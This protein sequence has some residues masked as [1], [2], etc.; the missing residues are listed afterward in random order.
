MASSKW[1]LCGSEVPKEALRRVRVC[2]SA[3]KAQRPLLVAR[4][5][6]EQSLRWGTILKWELAGPMI[7]RVLGSSRS[8]FL[9]I[10][11]RVTYLY[12]ASSHSGRPE[13]IRNLAIDLRGRVHFDDDVFQRPGF[14]K[15]RVDL[16]GNCEEC[17]GRIQN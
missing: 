3:E 12:R 7:P 11:L 5:W 15:V 10:A 13:E 9:Q 4:D 6:L 1:L 8:V 17:S 2:D 16:R 14:L